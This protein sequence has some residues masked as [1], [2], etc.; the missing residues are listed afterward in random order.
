MFGFDVISI[1]DRR[2]Q[3]VSITVIEKHSRPCGSV[4][5]AVTNVE[6]QFPA[7]GGGRP[8]VRFFLSC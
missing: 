4:G 1:D 2:F 8:V 5:K 3:Y 7:L 6:E